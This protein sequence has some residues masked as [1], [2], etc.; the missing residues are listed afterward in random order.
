MA[1]SKNGQVSAG[2][3]DDLGAALARLDVLEPKVRPLAALPDKGDLFRRVRGSFVSEPERW[4]RTRVCWPSYRDQWG[5]WQWTSRDGWVLDMPAENGKRTLGFYCTG[6]FW[7]RVGEM[8]KHADGTMTRI[9]PEGWVYIFCPR[10]RR[11][12]RRHRNWRLL[13]DLGKRD[14]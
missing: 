7:I 8:E 10:F 3:R 9:N 2:Y 1:M 12:I 11:T 5:S 4:G 14:G 6:C 13:R